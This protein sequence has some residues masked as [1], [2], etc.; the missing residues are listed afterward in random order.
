MGNVLKW[1]RY[2]PRRPRICFPGAVYHVFQRGN[3]KRDIF[4]DDADKWHF[5]KLF[6]EVK[7]TA[8]FLI[9]CY[10]LMANHF[11]ITIETPGATP[12]S[13]IMQYVA[14]SYAMYFNKRYSRKGHRF[15]GRFN[16]VLVQK[17]E[18]LMQLSRYVHL[19]PVK[20][21]IVDMPEEYKWSSYGIYLGRRKDIL[22]NTDMVL[23]CFGSS[24]DEKAKVGYKNFVEKGLVSLCEE[25][26]WLESNLIVN[27]FLGSRDFVKKFRNGV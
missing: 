27:K 15:E 11:H 3:S 26:D 9:Y 24:N 14:G 23:S 8:R 25:K 4:L 5:L 7:K 21:G 1:R 17:D 13:K 16:D 20:A 22:V 6:L 12:I 10:A 19:N 2:M 18:Y